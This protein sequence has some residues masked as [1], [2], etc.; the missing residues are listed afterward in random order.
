MSTVVN[1]TLNSPCYSYFLVCRYLDAE[2]DD[3]LYNSNQ[4]RPSAASSS[5]D[6]NGKFKRLS[7]GSRSSNDDVKTTPEPIIRSKAK[8]QLE[9]HERRQNEELFQL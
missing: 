2:E 8:K 7:S 6:R 1:T 5:S 3:V 4:L 9:Q